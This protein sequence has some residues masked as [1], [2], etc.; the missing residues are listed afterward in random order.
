M[1]ERFIASYFNWEIGGVWGVGDTL[2]EARENMVKC[3]KGKWKHKARENCI[4]WR[5]YSELPF[6]PSDRDATEQESDCWF[7][8]GTVSWRRCERERIEAA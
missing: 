6:A 1:H 7:N 5:F 3:A 4:V 2:D 8:E